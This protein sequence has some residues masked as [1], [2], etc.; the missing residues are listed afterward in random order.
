MVATGQLVTVDHFVRVIVKVWMV[1]ELGEEEDATKVAE[2]S[3]P[4]AKRAEAISNGRIN[5]KRSRNECQEGISDLSIGREGGY[6]LSR[7]RGGNPTCY[8]MCS[9]I[10]S[11]VRRPP[12]GLE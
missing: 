1:P 5:E 11:P 2:A 6:L 9:R 8:L 10:Q 7:D 12:V 4:R 3:R